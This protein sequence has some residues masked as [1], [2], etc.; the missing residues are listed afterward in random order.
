VTKAFICRPDGKKVS[1]KDLKT[2]RNYG[3]FLSGK[4]HRCPMCL[5][6][7][8]N[9]DGHGCAKCEC[10]TSGLQITDFEKRWGKR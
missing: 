5:H 2:V 3:E 10:L 4:G 9:H 8:K 6:K 1:K 7:R